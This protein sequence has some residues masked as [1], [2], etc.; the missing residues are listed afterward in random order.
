MPRG[1]KRTPRIEKL[2]IRFEEWRQSRKGRSA[3]PDRLWAAAAELA[4][5]HGVHRTATALRLDGA[6]LKQR[7]AEASPRPAP[8]APAAF[9]EL[10]TP[11][12]LPSGPEY[13][14]EWEGRA[15]KLRIHC[16]GVSAAELAT[17]SRALQG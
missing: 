13:I 8:A 3:I 10:L 9:L 5:Q 11:R 12:A 15:G 6:R 7:M 1:G 4:R 14:I 16:K 17:L 2:R